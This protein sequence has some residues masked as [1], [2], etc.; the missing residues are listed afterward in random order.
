MHRIKMIVPVP[1]PDEALRLF[2]AQLPP[3]LVRD[4]IEVDF[5][6]AGGKPSM[7]D[8]LYEMALADTAVLE[9]GATAEK[10]GYAAV[11]VNSTSDSGVA[12]LRSLLSIPVVGPGQATMLAACLL[13]KRFSILTMWDRWRPIYDKVATEQG[14]HHRIASVRA[15]GVPP[16]TSELLSGKEDSVF[17]LLESEA[18][19]AIDDDGADVL[20][21]GSTTMYQSHLYLAERLP[22]PVLN[23]GIVAYKACEMLIDLALSHSKVAYVPPRSLLAAADA[24]FN[25]GGASASAEASSGRLR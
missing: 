15:I 20:M 10:E 21:L 8:S 5:V 24:T 13:G 11:C 22:V 14:L 9:A 18:R 19:R 23:P 17:A 16:D 12:G 25:T 6:A 7:L 2:A 1:A 4:D 3:G